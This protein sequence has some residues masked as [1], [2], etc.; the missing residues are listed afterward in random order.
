MKEAGE[1]LKAKR[2]LRALTRAQLA[3]LP[4]THTA[5]FLSRA[6]TTLTATAPTVRLLPPP[7]PPVHLPHFVHA[8]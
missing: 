3:T 7:P 5:A 6:A 8:A 1:A 4:Q 2:G